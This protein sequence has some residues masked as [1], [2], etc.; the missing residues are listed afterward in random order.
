VKDGGRE[1]SS[2]FKSQRLSSVKD[3]RDSS[4]KSPSKKID[5]FKAKAPA[6]ASTISIDVKTEDSPYR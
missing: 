5:S 1:R 4:V 3:A 2:T 6:A